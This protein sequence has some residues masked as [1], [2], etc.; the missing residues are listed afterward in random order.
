MMDVLELA[1]IAM[2][3]FLVGSVLYVLSEEA[4]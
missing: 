3:I 4:L 1:S 2:L